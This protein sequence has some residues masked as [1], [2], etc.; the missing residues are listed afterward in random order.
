MSSD[1]NSFVNEEQDIVLNSERTKGKNVVIKQTKSYKCQWSFYLILFLTFILWILAAA[2]IIAL[3]LANKLFLVLL[4]ILS[5]PF[6]ILLIMKY[7]FYMSVFP[8]TSWFIRKQVEHS[9]SYQVAK[10]YSRRLVSYL[11]II[12]RMKSNK[13]FNSIDQRLIQEQTDEIRRMI[14]FLLCDIE[15]LSKSGLLGKNSIYDKIR[16]LQESLNSI[17]VFST[18]GTYLTLFELG[19]YL[20]KINT[21]FTSNEICLQFVVESEKEHLERLITSISDELIK[22]SKSVRCC[23]YL[24]RRA[25]FATPHQMRW[26]LINKFHARHY[27]IPINKTRRWWRLWKPIKIDT[28]LLPCLYSDDFEKE[29][30]AIE[31]C[32]TVILC[33]PNGGFIEY[34]YFQCEWV[35]FYL[36]K[37]VNV[38]LWNYRGYYNSTGTPNPLNIKEDVERVHDYLKNILRIKG[39]IGV[40]GESLG[41]YA[42]SHLANKRSIQFLYIDRSFWCLDKLISNRYGSCSNKW[43]K[44]I[45]YYNMHNDR[46]YIESKCFKI[47]A[48]DSLDLVVPTSSGL[49]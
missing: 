21:N 28:Y 19:E 1:S 7:V 22:Y 45:S 29:D 6:I 32:P 40:H 30:E 31:N 37:G 49:K 27:E 25:I 9:V 4:L 5:I 15:K 35:N 43:F 13:I 26:S 41:G 18:T 8:G 44:C 34:F 3:L 42:A 48:Q 36:E 23:G 47:I 24:W 39:I 46:N 16:N 33:F 12:R 10:V 38:L 2:L 11:D 14:D 20:E 17:K